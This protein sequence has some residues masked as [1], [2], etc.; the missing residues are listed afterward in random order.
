[1]KIA[2]ISDIHSNNYALESVIVDARR[3]GATEVWFLGDLFGYGPLPTR[4]WHLWRTYSESR[5]FSRVLSIPGNHDLGLIAD[6][7]TEDEG[8]FK[9]PATLTGEP[10]EIAQ[11]ND[12]IVK[13]CLLL[14]RTAFKGSGELPE[15]QSWIESIPYVVSPYSGVYLAHAFF[16]LSSRKLTVETYL[17]QMDCAEKSWTNLQLWL[18]TGAL[19]TEVPVDVGETLVTPKLLIVGHTHA[20]M[21]WRRTPTAD[22]APSW[23]VLRPYFGWQLNNR[24]GTRP[25]PPN[26][27]REPF[28]I[29][30]DGP[31]IDESPGRVTVV[32]PGS[33]GLPRDSARAGEGVTWAKY[34]L[35]DFEP[36][37]AKLAFRWVPYE[38]RP[39]LEKLEELGYPPEL[40]KWLQTL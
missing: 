13:T 16:D 19:E 26:G 6:T 4:T 12:R 25:I 34:A 11:R 9:L 10:I 32:N 20:Q 21:A 17:D 39:L 1:M 31:L 7:D 37:G 28:Q 40:D 27:D 30:I 36:P 24:P 23:E 33:V 14:N 8:T 5:A 35:I 38:I 2:V 22:G 15:V 18:D 29:D 3:C